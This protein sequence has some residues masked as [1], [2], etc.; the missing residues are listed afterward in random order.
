MADSR[1]EVRDG[2]VC[3]IDALTGAVIARHAPEATQVVQ[4]LSKGNCLIIR[5]DYYHFPEG[6]SNLICLDHDLRRLWT[7]ELPSARDVY[8]NPVIDRGDV[9]ECGT[10]EGFT[11]VIDPK[12]GQIVRKAFTK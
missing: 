9:L 2:A 3:K 10:W 8:A 6:R 11:C 12:T 7:A 4:V 1:L 5:E